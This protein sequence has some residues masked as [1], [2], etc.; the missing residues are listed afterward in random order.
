[1]DS[2]K[3]PLIIG[4]R[5]C[6]YPGIK[7]NS[8]EAVKQ[9]IKE[10][11]DIVEL[12]VVYAKNNFIGFHPSI[13]FGK[14]FLSTCDCD[15]F[16]FLLKTLK[17]QTPIYVDIKDNLTPEKMDTLSKL[18]KK[19]HTKQVIIG[20]YYAPVLKYFH[21]IE[22]DWIINYHCVATRKNIQ[23]A[24]EIGVN[25]INPISIGVSRKFV[26]T[27]LENGLKFVP[28]GNEN[29]KKQLH[30]AKLGA[31]ALSTFKPAIFRNWLKNKL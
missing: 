4:H 29:Y 26:K 19:Y 7:E 16:E 11:A 6:R 28:S 25:W 24:I 27:A 13:I 5:G 30:Y 2:E 31:Y 17:D 15:P 23:K 12:D 1:M 9:A 8:C 22:P 21:K 18:I 20:S 14:L 10:G 3:L